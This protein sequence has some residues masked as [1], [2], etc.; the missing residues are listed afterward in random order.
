MDVSE[1]APPSPTKSQS[2]SENPR[3][4]QNVAVLGCTGS[5]GTASVDVIRNL[6]ER[7]PQSSWRLWAASGHRNLDALADVVRQAN[8]A[9][10][11]P[12]RVIFSDPSAISLENA[13]DRF[14]G[15]TLGEDSFRFGAAG[16]VEIAEDP[17][18]DV[19]VA[20]IVGRAGL[21]STIA[22][23]DAGKR[24]ALANKETLVV[25]GDLVQKKLAASGASLLPVDSEHSAIFQCIASADATPRKL[26][27][28]ASGG[29]F[30]SATRAEMEAA[31][32]QDALAHPTWQMGPKITIDSATMMNK[33][34]EII[35]ARWLF[36]I[37]SHRIEVVIHPQSIIHSM[38][39]FDD[40]SVLSQMS[41]P[42]MRMPI[43]YALTF[44]RRLPCPA[45]DMDFTQ[46]T[47]LSLLPADLDRFPA[48]QLGFEVARVGGTAGVVV[49]AA[50]EIAV[51]LFLD[52]KI[53]FTEIVPTCQKVLQN[54]D[55]E[56]A[57]TLSRLLELDRWAR[58]EACR[59]AVGLN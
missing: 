48:L 21:E 16:L 28:T 29:P 32:P 49:N 17:Q 42:D 1:I 9:G 11:G 43:Q 8:D 52:Q 5:I 20:A 19:V 41:P 47:E 22:A 36:D 40:G 35:E 58:E 3:T 46:A 33:A 4:T 57:P 13:C 56:S 27:L 12:E 24:V 39:E 37:P 51:G 18:V 54:H 7:D 44:P 45:P 23:V 53:R 14:S 59:C 26:I 55:F 50:N 30:R 10:W 2:L 34:L 15:P 31:T 6:N 25:A 38:V